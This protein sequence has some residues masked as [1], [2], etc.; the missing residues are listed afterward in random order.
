MG[1]GWGGKTFTELSKTY[2]LIIINNK[3]NLTLDIMQI[4]D[5]VRHTGGKFSQNLMQVEKRI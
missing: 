1:E 3:N 4:I 5:Q 2:K